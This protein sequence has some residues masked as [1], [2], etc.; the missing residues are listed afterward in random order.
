[1]T[2]DGGIVG[3]SN[4]REVVG[5][6]EFCVWTSFC[7]DGDTGHAYMDIS[8]ELSEDTGSSQDSI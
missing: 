8:Y 5:D 3:F 7:D 2:K 6:K 4:I 1:M